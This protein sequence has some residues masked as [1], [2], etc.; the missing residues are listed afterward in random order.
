MLRKYIFAFVCFWSLAG[1][2]FAG[3]YHVENY[4]GTVGSTPIHLSLQIYKGFGSGINV[5]G[6]YFEDK[7]RS[8][9]PLYG[10]IEGKKLRFCEIADDKEFQRIMVYGSKKPV[11]TSNC[12][13]SIELTDD[14]AKG[15]WTKGEIQSPVVLRKI[16]M[17]DDTGE[18]IVEGK[19]EIPFWAQ[20]VTHTFSGIYTKSDI[21]ICMKKLL[22]IDK[23]NGKISQEIISDDEDCAGKAMTQIYRNVE[24]WTGKKNMISV[25]LSGKFA[26]SINYKFNPKTGKL[27]QIK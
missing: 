13:L 22:V 17:L 27:R 14:T 19:V 2:A 18:G 11:D 25:N 24:K 7:T 20:T 4:E 12:P 6:N 21:G 10:K 15:T 9:V 23:H 8:T 5:E 16:A 3:W 1:K 26:D